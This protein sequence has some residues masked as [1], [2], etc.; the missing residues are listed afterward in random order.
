M[1]TDPQILASYCQD[2]AQD[3]GAEPPLALVRPTC[4]AEVQA[5]VRWCAAHAVGLVTRGAGSGLSGGATARAGTVVLCTER[6]RALHIDPATRTATVQPGL[7]NAEVKAAAAQHGLWYPPDPSSFEFCSIGGNVATNAGG[8][9]CVKYGVT[10]DYVLGLEVVL[11]DGRA[12]RLGGR[13]IKDSA[14]LALTQLFVGSEG[15]LGIITEII[16][17]LLPAQPPACTVVGIFPTVTAA[18]RAV[19]AVMDR[20]RPAMLEFMDAV[21]INAVE[22][23]LRMGLP[24][25]AA[26]LL[27]AQS[28]A[29]GAAGREEIQ[30]IQQA[31]DAHG[32]TESFATD[33]AA[34][35]EAF[36]AARREA[37]PAVEALGSLLLEDVG[38]PL[39]Q[40]PALIDGV[41]GIAAAQDVTISVIAHAGDGNTHP[42]IVY[43]PADVA[44]QERAQVAFGQ[45]MDLAISLE[46]TITGEHGVG[47]LKKAWLPDQLGPEVMD[48]SAAIKTALDPAGVLNPGVIF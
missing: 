5:I 4:T 7:L 29:P 8:L 6:M 17:R 47:R 22:D 44:Q 42:L 23:R 32:A 3:P 18:G 24:R 45:V 13:R 36:T 43:D 38:V 46:G 33:D 37:I 28:D 11:A 12:V 21:A 39:P 10:R 2:R 25:D 27:V 40:L 26:A 41:A 30:L 19:L 1:I 48:L 9:C 35:G 20:L 34:E 16:L 31:F 15:A 14:G